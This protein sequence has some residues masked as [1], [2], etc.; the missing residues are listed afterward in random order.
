VAINRIY[1]LQLEGNINVGLVMDWKAAIVI[2]S[3]KHSGNYMYRLQRIKKLRLWAQSV[4]VFFPWVTL[5]A[6]YF[7]KQQ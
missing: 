2:N 3:G 1:V 5:N 6:S 7:P 4:L